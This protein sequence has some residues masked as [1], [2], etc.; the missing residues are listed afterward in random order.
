MHFQ[1]CTDLRGI[2]D[3]RICACANGADMCMQGKGLRGDNVV[4]TRPDR[5]GQYYA[6]ET[7]FSHALLFNTDLS[8]TVKIRTS[9]FSL[10]PRM[11]MTENAESLCTLSP[12]FL[13]AKKTCLTRDV[14][15]K[16]PLI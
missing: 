10:F 16:C 15:W 12:V 5:E 3:V 7:V 13:F 6:F 11:C 14:A 8:D 1:M 2:R 9:I 4:R